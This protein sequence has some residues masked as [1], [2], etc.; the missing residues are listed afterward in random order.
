VEADDIAAIIQYSILEESN[1]D[2][3]SIPSKKSKRTLDM[4]I[5]KGF[6]FIT[7]LVLSLVSSRYGLAQTLSTR[8]RC[9]SDCEMKISGIVL[10]ATGIT[11]IVLGGV[12][13]ASA[14]SASL[15]PDRE[16]TPEDVESR[17][18]RTISGAVVFGVGAVA[19]AIGLPLWIIGKRL[20]DRGR[21]R[22]RYLSDEVESTFLV[23]P[24]VDNNIHG[25]SALYRIEF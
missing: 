23:G 7:T 22:H 13:M 14:N 17:R 5:I 11:G 6:F 9:S 18:R 24:F 21:K 19:L 15:M 25:L 4:Y 3:Q 1:V 2:R 8:P 16:E 10:S 20:M 12:L